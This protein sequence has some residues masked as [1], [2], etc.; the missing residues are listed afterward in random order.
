M[1]VLRQTD[2]CTTSTAADAMNKQRA[3]SHFLAVHVP[4][5]VAAGLRQPQG[6]DVAPQQQGSR[7]IGQG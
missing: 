5:Q 6:E 2:S 3:V 4:A 1:V 7:N